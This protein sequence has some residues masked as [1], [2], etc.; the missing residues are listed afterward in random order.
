MAVSGDHGEPV[1]HGDGGD[2]EVEA[3]CRTACGEHLCLD[4]AKPSRAIVVEWVGDELIG[5]CLDPLEVCGQYPKTRGVTSRVTSQVSTTSG[6][7]ILRKSA[8]R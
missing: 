1:G 4:P 5:E 2:G 7:P 8:K 6:M 3:G